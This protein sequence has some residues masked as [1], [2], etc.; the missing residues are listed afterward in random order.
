M[1][2]FSTAP[3]TAGDS[4]YRGVSY[5]VLGVSIFSFQDVAIKWLSA[6]YT[7]HEIMFVRSF[8]AL[9]AIVLIAWMTE[10]IRALV[11]RRPLLHLWR[12]CATFG[13]YSLYYLGLAALPLADAVTLYF[14]C[15]LFITLLAILVLGEPVGWRRFLAIL[16]GFSG[17][18]IMLRPGESI[19]D[20]A[21]LLVLASSLS[22][23]VSTIVTRRLGVFTS[24][25]SM[26]FSANFV[27]LVASGLIGLAFGRGTLD[28]GSHPSLS[29]MLRAWTM[30]DWGDFGLMTLCGLIAGVGFYC[31]TQAYRVGRAS[32]VAPFEY[33]SLPW[34]ALWGWLAWGELPDWAT[35]GGVV[36]IVGSGLYVLRRERKTG[37][38]IVDGKPLRPRI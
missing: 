34:A 4:P 2:G 19:V 1:K 21:A 16:V 29:F 17:V 11:P 26:A 35:I 24:G 27:N 30:P 10:G 6:G 22:Y 38:G 13:A 25:V 31:L 5:L 20:V 33:V 14:S 15:P 37:R 3:A 23:A 18:V 12:S 7:V 36:L 9:P 8:I 32:M 28:T